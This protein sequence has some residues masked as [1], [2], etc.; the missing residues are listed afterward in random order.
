MERR[1]G[2]DAR[3]D[4]VGVMRR[5]GQMAKD[6][7]NDRSSACNFRSKVSKVAGWIEK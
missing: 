6:H 3:G 4:K 5:A 2:D 7:G 1:L